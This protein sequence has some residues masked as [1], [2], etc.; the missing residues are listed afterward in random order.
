MNAV[1]PKNAR[2]KQL[3]KKENWKVAKFIDQ[4]WHESKSKC[5]FCKKSILG[6]HLIDGLVKGTPFEFACMCPT[7]HQARGSGFGEGKGQLYTRLTNGQFL[8]TFGFS[9]DELA[10]FKENEGFDD[11]D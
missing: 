5:D 8:Q 11:E 4:Y 1:D 9:S 10:E 7:C 6:R 3:V 2:E